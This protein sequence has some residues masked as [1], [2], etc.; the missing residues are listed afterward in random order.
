M[1]LCAH[2]DARRFSGDRPRIDR[3]KTSVPDH[4]ATH[5]AKMDGARRNARV[6]GADE[7]DRVPQ[8]WERALTG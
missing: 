3:Q 2:P 6:L 5:E 7:F 8:Q 4:R 1:P